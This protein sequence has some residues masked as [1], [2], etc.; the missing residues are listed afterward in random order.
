MSTADLSIGF[1]SIPKRS[2]LAICS[3]LLRTMATTTNEKNPD[4]YIEQLSQT[5]VDKETYDDKREIDLDHARQ[6]QTGYVEGTAEEKALVRKLDWRLVVRALV[7]YTF[8]LYKLTRQHSLAA[9]P[10][11]SSPTL[12]A[13]TLATPKLAAW[14]MTSP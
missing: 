4:G 10:S 11:T 7:N 12:T 6:L 1:S 2:A 13:V 14:K 9:G 3:F 8:D 5:Q